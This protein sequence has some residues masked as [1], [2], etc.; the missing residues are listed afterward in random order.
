MITGRNLEEN[1]S[2]ARAYLKPGFFMRLII[3][4][5]AI[6]SGKVP[7]LTVIGRSSGKPRRVPI[8]EPV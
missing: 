3:D 5:L 1:H 4:P 2:V 7:V 8:G 6:R